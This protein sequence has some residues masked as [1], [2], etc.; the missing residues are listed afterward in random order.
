MAQKLMTKTQA[1]KYCHNIIDNCYIDDDNYNVDIYLKEKA[2]VFLSALITCRNFSIPC[3]FPTLRNSIQFEWEYFPDSEIYSQSEYLE[4]EIYENKIGMLY[5]DTTG[6]FRNLKPGDM[7][8]Y[9]CTFK[10]DEKADDIWW[11][12]NFFVRVESKE[13]PVKRFLE[14]FKTEY[15]EIEEK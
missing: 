3:I 15:K 14:L 11:V 13:E 2:K 7:Y 4:F 8:H 5:A 10:S 1:I 6:R 9:G 12:F